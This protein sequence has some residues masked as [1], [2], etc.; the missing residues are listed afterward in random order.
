MRRQPLVRP[1]RFILFSHGFGVSAAIYSGLHEELASRGYV[2]AGIEHTFDAGAVQFPDGR[3]VVQ[4]PDIQIDE[5]LRAVRTADIRFVLDAFG[6]LAAGRNPD[7]GH[8]RLPAGLGRT[9]DLKRVGAFGHSLGSPA[10]V[11]AMERDRR[12]DVGIVLDGDL[13]TTGLDRPFLMI[14][15]QSQRRADSPEW[16][17]FY[18]NLS[19]PRLHSSSKGPHMPTSATSRSLSPRST[20]MCL[21]PVP[22]TASAR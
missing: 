6:A 21:L 10:L 4:K 22:S 5:T 11:A 1:A 8:R 15:N 19:G 17:A 2:V 7:A 3:L 9:L 18:D 14:G 12:I 13:V 20:L 16:A